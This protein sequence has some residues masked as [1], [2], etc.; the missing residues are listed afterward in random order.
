MPRSTR[1]SKLETRTARLRLQLGVRHWKKIGK[2][3]FL[4]YRRTAAGYG[5][6]T[7]RLL[8]SGGRTYALKAIGSADDFQDANGADVLTFFQ[9]QDRARAISD[10]AKRCTGMVR[11]PLTVEQ[12]AQHY[13]AW[14]K[15]NRRAIDS[16]QAAIAAH[17]IPALGKRLLHDLNAA[18]LRSWLDNL[19]AQPARARTSKHASVLNLRPPPRDADEKRA[20]RATANRVLGMLKA[21]LNRAFQ[22]GDVPDDT[23][24]RQVKPFPKVDE[25]RIRY[26][27]SSESACLVSA[28]CTEVR[29]LVRGALLTGARYSELTNLR[30]QDVNLSTNSIYIAESKSGR[31][32]H[33]PLNAE[34]VALFSALTIGR[35]AAAYVFVRADGRQWLKN[36]QVR[37][38]TKACKAGKIAPAITFHELRHTYAS[39]LAQAGIDL[40][41][42]SK[43]LGHADTRITAKHYAHLADKTLAAA[44][45]KLPALD[46][47]PGLSIAKSDEGVLQN[48]PAMV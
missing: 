25:A 38:L 1:D 18:E 17:I 15:Q 11:P 43:L 22:N 35:D 39:Q 30:V 12:A 6:W 2:G 44:V 16:T 20:R 29:P 26:L 32:R 28:C 34:G 3:L 31:P 45:L 8:L 33:V 37:P 24:W 27:T 23:P 14:Y 36:H 40:L 42:I 7:A 41:T 4:G 13:L 48:I 46:P 5:T 10:E 47:H 19:A 9:A 21:I